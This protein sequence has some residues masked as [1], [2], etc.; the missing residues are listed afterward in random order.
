[1]QSAKNLLERLRSSERER[2]AVVV[3]AALAIPILILV[4]LG[5]IEFGFGWEAKSANTAAVRTG[6]LRA[7]SIG[8]K[9]ETD[10]RILQSVI[11]EVGADNV[12]RVSWVVLFEVNG[13]DHQATA[14]TCATNGGGGFGVRCVYYD[15]GDLANIL[16]APDPSAFQSANFDIGSGFDEAT[17]LYNCDTGKL[18]SGDF[19]A[20]A[21]TASGDIEIGLA[22]R[23]EHEW[24]TGIFP[25]D[26]PTFTDLTVSSTF[27][28]EGSNISP[29]SI[30]VPTLL[31]QV[32]TNDFSTGSDLSGF[33]SVSGGQ[34]VQVDSPPNHSAQILGRFTN[35]KI[36][37][38]VETPQAVAEPVEVCVSFTL[39]IIGSWDGDDSKWG[40]DGFGL[41][42]GK[43][44]VLEHDEY[45]YHGTQDQDFGWGGHSDTARS[46]QIMDKCAPHQ[47]GSLDISF[48]GNVS[49]SLQNESWAISDLNVTIGSGI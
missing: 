10:M 21:R 16:A 11:S 19:C 41:D 48:I 27:I 39:W 23:Y 18:D 5:S 32:Y 12:D 20:G 31:G 40:D 36:V 24:A 44:G 42:I 47:G 4:I 34:P 30:N 49:E 17:G 2:G 28:A 33:T 38:N 14:E 26:P 37:L 3:E 22:V 25:F 1:M 13:T 9:P 35:D 15:S 29:S 43:D 46:V 45:Y 6:L 8:D 7:A